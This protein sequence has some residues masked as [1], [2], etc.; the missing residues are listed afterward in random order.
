LT[1]GGLAG[2]GLAGRG[3]SRR[4]RLARPLGLAML[5]LAACA[6]CALAVTSC[7]TASSAGGPPRYEVRATA[8]SGLGTILADGA[9]FTLYMYV[10][11][12]RGPSTCS[13]ACAVA[14]PPLVLPSG[15]TRPKAGPGIRA[16]LLGTTRRAGGAL[17][18]TYDKWPLYLWQGDGAPG[19]ATGQAEDMGSWYVLSVNGSIDRGTPS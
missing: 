14:W 17:Q 8:I 5:A 4:A 6:G 11:D 10:P 7:G 18:V 15:V 13:R 3:L 2:R 12:H 1:G 19:Q 16:A 9:G